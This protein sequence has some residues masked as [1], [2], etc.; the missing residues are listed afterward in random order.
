MSR[1]NAHGFTVV[2]ALVT[3]LLLAVVVQ[4]GW[5][6]FSSFRRGAE[7]VA[8]AAQRLETIR[9]VGWVLSEE[10]SGG[11]LGQDWWPGGSTDS[12]SLRA[13]RG[14]AWVVESM[15]ESPVRV[16]YRGIR[17]PNPE[18]DSILALGEDGVWFPLALLD[19]ARGASGCAGGG[20]G[21]TESWTVEEEGRGWLLGRIFER[22][23]YHFSQGAL[24]YRR[25]GGGRQPLT[26]ENLLSGAFHTA[27]GPFGGVDWI[28][29]V[30]VQGVTADSL[31]W[32]GRLR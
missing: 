4:G 26:A 3:L 5:A 19:R 28:V 15:G 7:R 8:L 20:E 14:V 24:R 29:E 30:G 17:N 9:T 18:K 11:R 25:G 21:W 31:P 2:E 6:V 1:G 12:L 16:C 13:Y 27:S 32:R 23:S 22:G 10:L